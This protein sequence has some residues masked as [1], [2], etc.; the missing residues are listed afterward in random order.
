MSVTRNTLLGPTLTPAG[1]DKKKEP[2]GGGV[3]QM[4]PT[5]LKSNLFCELKPHDKIQNPRTTTS[6]EK[7]E[8]E[9][10]NTVHSCHYIL[11]AKPKGSEYTQLRPMKKKEKEEEKIKELNTSDT[12]KSLFFS[13]KDPTS[14]FLF[15]QTKTPQ[16]MTALIYHIFSG[17]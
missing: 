8:R 11:P 6:G 5:P 2:P 14:P 3:P 4:P 1:L 12:V 16:K 13:L 10:K 7:K 15:A 17:Y 9:R